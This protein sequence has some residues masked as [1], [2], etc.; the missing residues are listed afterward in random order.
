[1]DNK[2]STK[3]DKQPSWHQRLVR[4][5][6]PSASGICRSLGYSSLMLAGVCIVCRDSVWV[7]IA[8]V[9]IGHALIC[10]AEVLSPYVPNDKV[11]GHGG[12]VAQ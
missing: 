7:L 9:I 10:G 2:N 1:M 12:N 4:L 11:Q 3:R 6:Q 8:E 5:F